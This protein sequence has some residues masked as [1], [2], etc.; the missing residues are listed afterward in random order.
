MGNFHSKG[1]NATVFASV[2]TFMRSYTY[3]ILLQNTGISSKEKDYFAIKN[4]KLLVTYYFGK[5]LRV[6]NILNICKLTEK[7]CPSNKSRN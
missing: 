3:K 6:L 1:N 4:W 7:Y 2:H 5:S